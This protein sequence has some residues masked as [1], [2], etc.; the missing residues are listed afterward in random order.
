M[1]KDE[2]PGCRRVIV[3]IAISAAAIWFITT[4][5]DRRDAGSST[6]RKST[7]TYR[8]IHAIGNAESIIARGLSRSACEAQ[9]REHI[10]VAESL[11]VHNEKTGY[12]SIVCLPESS[13]A[14]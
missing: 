2:K 14:D 13:F 4:V 7:E 8:L 1:S 9:K 12:G 10:A 3:A 11:G 6:A 5:A